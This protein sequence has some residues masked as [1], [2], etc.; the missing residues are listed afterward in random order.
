MA[1]GPQV[2]NRV[3]PQLDRTTLK[4]V[5]VLAGAVEKCAGSSNMASYALKAVLKNKTRPA[6]DFAGRAFD[7]LEPKLRKRI[8]RI[9]TEAASELV[10]PKL[11]R[12][13]SAP[14]KETRWVVDYR[15][16]GGSEPPPS[17]RS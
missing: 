11:P 2:Q 5:A 12:F 4:A 6:L 13:L 7:M 3:Q 16:P 10:K 1:S 8:G 17:Q 9:A 15:R 14:L